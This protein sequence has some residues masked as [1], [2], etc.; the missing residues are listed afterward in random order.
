MELY[1][2]SRIAL[3]EVKKFIIIFYTV[4]FVGFLIPASRNIF[5][6]L[7]PLA[8][9]LCVYLLAV[10][11]N[12]YNR[13]S[14]LLFLIIYFLGFSVEVIGVNTGV[15]FGHYHYGA[16][17]A[18]KV[19]E[20][21]LMIGINW[22]FLVYIS[23][24]II[25]SFKVKPWITILLAPLLILA[26]DLFLEQVAPA[27]DMWHWEASQVPLKNYFAWLFISFVFV[28]IFK[29]FKIKTENTLAKVLF[30]CQFLFFGLLSLTL[31]IK[32]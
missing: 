15:I 6:R 28:G 20:T 10:Y 27:L 24:S 3:K 19:F 9:L 8:L 14:F 30:I 1:P 11:H 12:H 5:I 13:K 7:T 22:L 29:L 18:L 21:P 16:A 25:D 2:K 23:T 32:V 26:Y 31:K 4:G 17:L